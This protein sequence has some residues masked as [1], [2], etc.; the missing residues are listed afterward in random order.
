VTRAASTG[1][2]Y[3]AGSSKIILVEVR[4]DQLASTGYRYVRLKAV[5]SVN[6]PVLGGCSSLSVSR[7]TG[8]PSPTARSTD[9]LTSH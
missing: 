4:A 6:S 7:A 5:E 8:R 1:F 3:T 9:P 2:V